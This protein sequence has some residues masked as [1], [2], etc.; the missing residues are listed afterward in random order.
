MFGISFSEILLILL[1][2][3][4]VFGP[5]QLPQIART[6][7]TFIGN[8]YYYFNRIKQEVY[9]QSGFSEL[10]LAKQDLINTYQNL[11]NPNTMGNTKISTIEPESEQPHQLEDSWQNIQNSTRITC[12]SCG[13]IQN[14]RIP[15]KYQAELDFEN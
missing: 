9:Q 7:G 15:D 11:T 12:H 8:L 5:K 4:I 3:L 13:A 2:S 14:E 6:I 1:I 10:N